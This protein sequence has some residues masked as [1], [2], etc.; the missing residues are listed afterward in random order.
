[1]WVKC[2]YHA[3]LISNMCGI[4]E[5]AEQV[6]KFARFDIVETNRD[7]RTN[8]AL[9]W[10]GIFHLAWHVHQHRVENAQVGSIIT[11]EQNK[12]FQRQVRGLR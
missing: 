10:G 4:D 1:M 7:P 11:P 6:S 12:D 5:V 3:M 2:F 9:A 8:I